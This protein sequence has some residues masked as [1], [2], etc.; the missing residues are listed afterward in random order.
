MRTS[1]TPLNRVSTTASHN[2][3]LE[4]GYAAQGIRTGGSAYDARMSNLWLQQNPLGSVLGK[5]QVPLKEAG[6]YKPSKVPEVIIWGEGQARI[7]MW[8]YSQLTE[9]SRVNLRQR[10][11]N[12]RDQVGAGRLLPLQASGSQAQV[13]SWLITAQV[14]LAQSSGYD[15]SMAD[16]GLPES[17][18]Q[19]S[20]DPPPD[21]I[22]DPHANTYQTS[23][24]A[25]FPVLDTPSYRQA[26][27]PP[28]KGPKLRLT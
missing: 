24:Q 11:L 13:V 6:A 9:L 10:A 14:H 18:C 7:P 16:L 12:L 1:S 8:T 23:T 17:E 15:L 28:R 21:S 25:Q 4:F 20:F 22:A 5:G 2:R 19:A 26:P 27:S 3:R